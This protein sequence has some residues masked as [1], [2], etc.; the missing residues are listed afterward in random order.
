[1]NRP[2]YLITKKNVTLKKSGAELARFQD[3]LA[4]AQFRD[5]IADLIAPTRKDGKSPNRC[6]FCQ[7]LPMMRKRGGDSELVYTG[8]A[9]YQLDCGGIAHNHYVCAYG[10]TQRS[11]TR[12]WNLFSRR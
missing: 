11:V 1:M 3:T 10:K 12:N 2:K 7:R 9:F 4:A 6:P 5:F 8:K